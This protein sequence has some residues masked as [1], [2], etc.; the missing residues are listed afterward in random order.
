MTA[1]TTPSTTTGRANQKLRTRTA[2]LAAA[3][4]L[5]RTGQD[6][7]MLEV[8]KSALVSEATAYRYFPDLAS[9]LQEA[10]AGQMPTPQEALAAVA[11]SHD[12]VERVA[13]ATEH[14]LRLVLVYQGA[15]RAMIAATITRPDTVAARPGLRFGLIDHA[16]APVADTLGAAALQQ[17]K[18]DLAV[19]VSA[20]ALFCLTD[21]CALAPEDAIASAVRTATTLTRSAVHGHTPGSGPLI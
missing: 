11:D 19:V 2:I 12:P 9:L 7:S 15:T 13:A 10:M 14:L 17:L 4:E 1:P 8:A 6:V 5:M 16:L 3:V 21:L 20:E 18:N